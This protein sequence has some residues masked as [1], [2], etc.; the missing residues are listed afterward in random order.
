MRVEFFL[1]NGDDP[2]VD[3]PPDRHILAAAR[4]ARIA[5]PSLC[6]QGWCCT[7]AVH[8]LEGYIDQ[9]DSRRVYEEDHQT[10]FGLICTGK[11]KTDLRF[12]T[13]ALPDMHAHRQ[14]CGLPVPRGGTLRDR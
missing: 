5:L 2:C 6:E 9:S 4:E 14:A 8:V 1:P 13:H 11:P 7:W 12:K 3:I 10:G